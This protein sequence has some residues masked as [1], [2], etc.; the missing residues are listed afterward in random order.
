LEY[1]S[2]GDGYGDVAADNPY[3]NQVPKHSYNVFNDFN[4]SS[5]STQYYVERCLQQWLS[6]YRIDGFRWDLTKGFTQNCSE[7][8]ETCTNAYQQDRVDILKHYADRQW[9]LDPNSYMIFEHLGTDAEEQQWANY[10]V[11]EGK[12]VMLWNKQ[13]EPYNQNTMGYKENSNY[14]RMNHSF[15]VLPICVP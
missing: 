3:F 9:A 6:E 12:G 13:T 1:R 2:D 4:H 10:R 15:M 5:S 8:D 11:A 7:N 14:D